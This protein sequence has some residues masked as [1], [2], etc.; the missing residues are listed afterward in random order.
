MNGLAQFTCSSK[1]RECD[2]SRCFPLMKYRTKKAINDTELASHCTNRYCSFVHY[3]LHYPTS[4]KGTLLM[5]YNNFY[6]ISATDQG[7]ELHIC[8]SVL[9]NL[10]FQFGV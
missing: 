10:H 3:A 6:Q 8:R 1:M 4:S 7:S 2:K 5:N 9:A